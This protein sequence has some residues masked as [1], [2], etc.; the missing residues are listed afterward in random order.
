MTAIDKIKGA[1]GIY[2]TRRL[3]VIFFLGISSGLPL[4]L[5]LSTLSFWLSTEGL[6]KS[7]IGLFAILTTPY[8]L[9]PLWAPLVDRLP[10]PILT[11]SFGRRRG[12]L[13][14]SQ[15]ALI[16][17]ILGLGSSSPS[18]D[19]VF[20]AWM[21]FFVAFAS[22]TQD[23]VID[24]YRIEILKKDEQGAGAAMIIFGYRFGN[25]LSGF[26]ALLIAASIGFGAAYWAMA[27]FVVS[28]GIAALI[29]GEPDNAATLI[30]PTPAGRSRFDQLAN[31][32]VTAVIDP[33]REFSTR[34]RWFLILFFVVIYKIGD[35][36]AS[37]MTAPFIVDMGFSLEEAAWANK[38]VGFWALLIGT[39]IGGSLI[40]WAGLFRALMIG[41]ILM[42]VSNLS[43]AALAVMGHNVP[44][45]V[46]TIGFENFATGLGLS[47]FVA[48]LSGLCN[49][50][51][52]ATQYALLSSLMAIGRT[53]VTGSSGFM[54][55]AW[56]WVNFFLFTTLAAVPGLVVLYL[57]WHWGFRPDDDAGS[58][59]QSKIPQ[60]GDG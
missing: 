54:V 30:A 10:L 45:L 55:E 6:D 13:F 21:A 27:A 38:M 22:A 16:A 17:A 3:L 25:L 2:F 49:I 32:F 39:Y 14:L 51:Y 44:M 50:A 46:F 35:A 57:L 15:A 19:L 41:G 5:V 23:I 42:M 12:W 60:A 33:F 58:Q 18:E 36:L 8:L 26:V 56:G 59:G 4:T 28:G 53:W 43:F 11:R 29:H 7:T 47:V 24:A 9:K 31:W 20:T 37:A 34:N 52:T 40:Y 48:Y 1:L